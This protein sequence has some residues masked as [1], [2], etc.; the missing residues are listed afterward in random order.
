M[1]IVPGLKNEEK[2]TF[3]PEDK[4]TKESASGALQ[5]LHFVALFKII[6]YL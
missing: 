6:Y 4:K 5:I 2:E 1:I 3:L